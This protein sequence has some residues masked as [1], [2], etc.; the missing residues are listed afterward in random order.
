M[1]GEQLTEQMLVLIAQVQDKIAKSGEWV[2]PA[3]LAARMGDGFVGA[4]LGGPSGVEAI[5]ELGEGERQVALARKT[6]LDRVGENVRLLAAHVPQ[7]LAITKPRYRNRDVFT[8]GFP[9]FQ[10]ETVDG[11]QIVEVKTMQSPAETVVQDAVQQTQLYLAMLED[12]LVSDAVLSLQ[13]ALDLQRDF[14]DRAGHL[15]GVDRIDDKEL[16]QFYERAHL[17]VP[18]PPSGSVF[19]PRQARLIPVARGLEGFRGVAVEIWKIRRAAVAE[20]KLPYVER[21]PALCHR[22]AFRKLCEEGESLELVPPAPLA[23]ALGEVEVGEWKEPSRIPALRKQMGQM[24]RDA[25]EKGRGGADF[26][27][28]WQRTFELAHYEEEVNEGKRL[29]AIYREFPDLFEKWGGEGVAHDRRLKQSTHIYYRT[30]PRKAR[31]VAP[32]PDL[33]KSETETLQKVKKRWNL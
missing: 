27:D 10:L 32:G 13:S 7:I 20:G 11:H 9:D 25:H 16:R 23:F 30:D 2:A 19:L 5:G 12:D 31:N 22:C 18:T 6:I 26:T 24:V 21:S 4:M 1:T 29:H 17:S 33:L 28:E 8:S 3:E 14:P 15:L